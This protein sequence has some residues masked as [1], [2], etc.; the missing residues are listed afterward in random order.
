MIH[1]NVTNR[2]ANWYRKSRKDFNAAPQR[3]RSLV[4][5]RNNYSFSSNS[6]C[7]KK[8]S[9]FFMAVYVAG[10][11]HKDN[12]PPADPA[13]KVV[14]LRVDYMS[15]TLEAMA[16]VPLSGNLQASD[17]IPLNVI[18]ASP[19]DFGNLT[20]LYGNTNDTVFDGS[21]IWMGTGSISIPR[22]FTTIM[23][24]T[25]I[26]VPQPDSNVYQHVFG[27]HAPDYDKLWAAIGKLQVVNNYLRQGKRPAYFLYTPSVGVGNP[28]EWDWFV[29]VTR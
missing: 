21:I 12:T 23:P 10:C 26:T 4:D 16:E 14:L 15:D 22:N 28:Y 17:T 7:M 8:L 13:N 25:S 24:A 2:K 11:T 29:L 9:L 20:L 1:I 18:Y 6:P 5:E 3:S 27:F 19:G